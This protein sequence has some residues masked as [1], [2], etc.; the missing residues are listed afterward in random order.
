M[1]LKDFLNINDAFTKFVNN[2]KITL[3]DGGYHLIRDFL[4]ENC[5]PFKLKKIDYETGT[6]FFIDPDTEIEYKCFMIDKVGIVISPT[7]F[8]I[9]DGIKI[10]ILGT[11]E[12]KD[13]EY[14]DQGIITK[15]EIRGEDIVAEVCTVIADYVEYFEDETGEFRPRTRENETSIYKNY[16]KYYEQYCDIVANNS[17]SINFA[18]FA[19]FVLRFLPDYKIRVIAR[20]NDQGIIIKDKKSI[21]KEEPIKIS[22]DVNFYYD[23]IGVINRKIKELNNE[24]VK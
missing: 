6:L 4:L 2:W 12:M 1:E 15:T 13:D 16:S 20:S 19:N 14:F 5:S 9:C 17:A 18:E 21:I 8:K 11:P 3:P 24:K 23:S 22:D 7:C 10:M